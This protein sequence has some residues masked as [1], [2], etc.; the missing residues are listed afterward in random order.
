MYASAQGNMGSL[1]WMYVGMAVKIAQNMKLN[2]EPEDLEASTNVKFTWLEREMRRRTWWATYFFDRQAAAG[3]D[4][5]CMIN[6]RECRVALPCNLMVFEGVEDVD[7]ETG[8]LTLDPYKPAKFPIAGYRASLMQKD[9][10]AHWAEVMAWADMQPQQRRMLDPSEQGRPA[11]PGGNKLDPFGQIV[12]IC[13]IFGKIMDFHDECQRLQVDAFN[14]NAL[15]VGNMR[16]AERIASLNSSLEDWFQCL[17]PAYK[18]TNTEQPLHKE[19]LVSEI[20]KQTGIIIP[21]YF[22]AFLLVFYHSVHIILHRPR[23]LATLGGNSSWLAS[24]SFLKCHHH[25]MALTKIMDDCM[26]HNPTLDFFNPFYTFCVFQAGLI[27]C[28]AMRAL[29]SATESD[30]RKRLYMDAQRD[31]M[32]DIAALQVLGLRWQTANLQAQLLTRVSRDLELVDGFGLM[33]LGDTELI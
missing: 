24:A 30:A 22:S 9:N 14:P 29:S 27:H 1:A 2:I 26:K 7:H 18:H 5:L 21:G 17:R 11:F 6:D 10:N 15:S 32:T 19:G 25:A 12:L 28:Y 4:R 23:N 3:A 16:P 13:C 8:Q 31:A 33:M 20:E